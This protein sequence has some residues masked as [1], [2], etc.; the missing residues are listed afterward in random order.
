MIEQTE[1]SRKRTAAGRHEADAL[2]VIAIYTVT[3]LWNRG[4]EG[5]AEALAIADASAEAFRRQ[6]QNGRAE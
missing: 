1:H 4:P 6:H 2:L 3:E 5:R